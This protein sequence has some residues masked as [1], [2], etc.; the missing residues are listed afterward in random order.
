MNL[1]DVLRRT[2]KIAPHVQVRVK[3][4]GDARVKVTYRCIV[5]K[6]MSDER[7]VSVNEDMAA[8]LSTFTDL[9]AHGDAPL[10]VN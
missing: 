7:V 10:L 2:M 3:P 1:A 9:H 6:T 4:F 5:C 8:S